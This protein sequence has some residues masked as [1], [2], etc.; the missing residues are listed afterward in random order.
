MAEGK[1]KPEKANPVDEDKLWCDR[2]KNELQSQN[3]WAQTYE[4]LAKDGVQTKEERIRQLEEQLGTKE[5]T[6]KG[7]RTTTQDDYQQRP[8]LEL[9]GKGPHMHTASKW[10]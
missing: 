10:S 9:F 5:M 4:Y 8:S 6:Y 3:N 1:K 2:I 7:L